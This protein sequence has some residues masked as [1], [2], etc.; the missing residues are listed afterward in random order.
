MKPR[1]V[2]ISILIKTGAKS[3]RHMFFFGNVASVSITMK[4]KTTF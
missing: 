4:N 2:N 1:Y 3:T